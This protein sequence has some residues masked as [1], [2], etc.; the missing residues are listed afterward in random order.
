MNKLLSALALAGVLPVIACGNVSP[1][2]SGKGGAG[3]GSGGSRGGAGGV[4]GSAGASGTGGS[5]G[6]AGTS[7]TGGGTAGTGGAAGSTDGGSDGSPG[8]DGGSDAPVCGATCPA[9]TWDLD[10]NPATGVCGCEYTCNKVSDA[11]PIDPNF[12]DDNCDGS[13]GV[14]AQ[15]V[16]VSATLGSIAGPGTREKPFSTIGNGILA[17]RANNLPAVCVGGGNYNEVV[18]VVP[19]ISI[20]GGF[21]SADTSFPF[22]RSASAVT[23][24]TAPGTTFDAPQIDT[25]THIEG[26]TIVAT[27]P[28]T[29]GASAYGVRLGG[30]AG[31]LFVRYDVI[32]V[33][34]GADGA[35]GVD[36]AAVSPAQAPSGNPGV[37]GT[38]AGS[39]GGT[40]GP[41]PTCTEFGGAGG[42]GGYDT[43][44][45]MSG[46]PGSGNATP[47]VG[48]TANTCLTGGGTAATDGASYATPGAQ[49]PAGS[50]G[51]TLGTISG[52]LYTPADGH[53]G[54]AGLNG[55]GGS[56]GGGG[57]GGGANTLCN[58]DRGG[59]GGSGG[60]GGLGGNLGSRGHGGGGS[61]G[62]FAAAG[63]ITVTNNDIMTAGGGHGGKGGNGSAGQS[64]GMGAHGGNGADDGEPGGAGGSGS[65]GGAGGPGGGG[66][67]G[68]SACLA[69]GSGTSVQYM[70]VNCASGAPG[71]GGVGGTNPSGIQA[72]SGAAGTATDN[73]QIN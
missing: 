46:S 49:G 17:A 56:G 26:L 8:T 38:S 28:T 20:Y 72:G 36:G 55:K 3:G 60:C 25:E 6:A 22:R 62:V 19:G 44:S 34:A 11:D 65:S 27:A 40:G 73:L 45:G 7:G 16:Y 12:T 53:D 15:C 52:G 70:T 32:R 5:A 64:G 50:G 31:R 58:A 35:P 39:S 1:M 54:T 33:G 13:D 67:G 2:A 66:A 23:T 47:G 69:H 10:K 48:G 51:L 71:L 59:G 61:F 21:D 30:G 41:R 4:S 68:P 43:G 24:V 57:G 42:L 9:G 63:M 18:S 37:D 14:V 29:P